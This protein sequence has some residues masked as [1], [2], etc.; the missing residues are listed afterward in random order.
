MHMDSFL[1]KLKKEHGDYIDSEHMQRSEKSQM[2]QS[3]S[4][5]QVFS[6]QDM[7]QI[8][9]TADSAFQ[10]FWSTYSDSFSDALHA[11][12][13]AR[14][15]KDKLGVKDDQA[16][17]GLKQRNA[18]IQQASRTSSARSDKSRKKH[19]AD[20]SQAYL[21]AAQK[22]RKMAEARKEGHMMDAVTHAEEM[23]SSMTLAGK[24]EIKATGNKD[25][26]EERKKL[27]L[28]V[29]EVRMRLNLYEEALKNKDLT[30]E[31]R[32]ELE[33]KYQEAA[34]LYSKMS[35]QLTVADDTDKGELGLKAADG[36]DDM[37]EDSVF[38]MAQA[39]KYNTDP[40]LRS[41]IWG[42]FAGKKNNDSGRKFGYIR[43]WVCKSVNHFLREKEKYRRSMIAPVVINDAKKLDREFEQACAAIR[44][45]A[46]ENAQKKKLVKLPTRA[47]LEQYSHELMEKVQGTI[48][49]LDQAVT[50]NT[51]EKKCK[52]YRMIDK[53]FLSWG[54][55]IPDFDKLSP[56]E[57]AAEI[58]KR[59]G[60]TIEDTGFMSTAYCVSRYFRDQPIMLTMLTPAGKKCYSTANF[61]EAEVI[62]GRNTRYTVIGAIN[63]GKQAKK[64]K[65]SA[66]I[67]DGATSADQIR[68]HETMDFTGLEVIC[69]MQLN[70]DEREDLAK[71]KNLDRKSEDSAWKGTEI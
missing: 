54:M 40:K 36:Y 41:G 14:D 43:T 29:K 44:T 16:Q 50:I 23:I 21:D 19:M 64:M 48:F 61:E 58:N 70:D 7:A 27:A 69:K 53:A 37:T 5:G 45:E 1:S 11:E 65:V 35:T 34:Q 13:R 22:H 20:S 17:A 52:V 15:V 12:A 18:Q 60:K 51:V 10:D 25:G 49:D 26:A 47:N 28:D 59:H 6:G 55:G 63:H 38:E 39:N 30:S 9:S 4:M 32:E 8:T 46:E 3:F 68:T 2:P 42:R 56:D 66:K 67:P 57:M 62:F 31:Q 24:E 71:R 33:K